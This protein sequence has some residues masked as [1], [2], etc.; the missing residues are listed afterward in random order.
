MYEDI[1]DSKRRRGRRL[2]GP[3]G[4]DSISWH[5]FVYFRQFGIFSRSIFGKRL[6]IKG[7]RCLLLGT[8]SLGTDPRLSNFG[9]SRVR[10]WHWFEHAAHQCRHAQLSIDLRPPGFYRISLSRLNGKSGQAFAFAV[11]PNEGG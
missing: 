2:A 1:K 9:S 10:G 5:F 7:T 11:A 8:F 4:A 3:G 6:T